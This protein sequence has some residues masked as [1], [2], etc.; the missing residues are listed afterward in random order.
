MKLCKVGFS[1]FPSCFPWER[2]IS[3]GR[4][5]PEKMLSA[6]DVAFSGDKISGIEER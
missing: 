6:A 3:C 2:G 5:H 1:M 4:K